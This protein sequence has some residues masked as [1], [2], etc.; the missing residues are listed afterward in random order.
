MRAEIEAVRA[1]SLGAEDVSPQRGESALAEQLSR[2]ADVPSQRW[3]ETV[4]VSCSRRTT[5]SIKFSYSARREP[6]RGDDLR[7]LQLPKSSF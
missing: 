2:G 5:S 1:S 4:E 3:A 6:R 7:A